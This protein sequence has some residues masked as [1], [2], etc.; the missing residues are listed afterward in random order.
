MARSDSPKSNADYVREW[1]KRHVL[2]QYV[3]NERTRSLIKAEAAR[4]GMSM[5][6]YIKRAILNQLKADRSARSEEIE[7]INDD[8]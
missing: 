4:Q 2:V 6:D 8:E 5:N 1:R 3:T 7:S